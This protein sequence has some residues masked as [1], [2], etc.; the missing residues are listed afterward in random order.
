[1]IYKYNYRNSNNVQK[2]S[3]LEF[4]IRQKYRGVN[5]QKTYLSFVKILTL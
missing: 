5:F 4:S 2:N 1:M 3:F